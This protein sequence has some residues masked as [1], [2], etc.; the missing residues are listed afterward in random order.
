MNVLPARSQMTF[1]LTR[2]YT[3]LAS[4]SKLSISHSDHETRVLIR[5]YSERPITHPAVRSLT[6]QYINAL[7]CTVRILP[8]PTI[9]PFFLRC[10]MIHTETQQQRSLCHT[11]AREW[12]IALVE[13]L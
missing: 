12:G 4:Y 8:S 10:A 7:Y 2:Y 1:K 6:Q 9:R 3:D 13:D 11:G 5:L